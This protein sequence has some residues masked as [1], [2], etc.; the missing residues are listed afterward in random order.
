MRPQKRNLRLWALLL[1]VL[2]LV[3][4]ACGG[5]DDDDAGGTSDTTAAPADDETPTGDPFAPQPLD[6]PYTIKMTTPVR[7]EVFA[8]PLLADFFDELAAEN[9]TLEVTDTPT[10]EALALLDAGRT[11]VHVTSPVAGFFNA[12]DQ[13]LNVRWA[14]ASN[15]FGPDSPTG[16]Y[17]KPDLF[18]PD[19]TVD[20][21]DLE[22]ARIAL[23]PSGWGDLAAGFFR[24]WLQDNGLD[25]DDIDIQSFNSV[26]ALTQLE[27]GN[28][29]GAVLADPL[30]E[31]A[32]DRGF[33][34]LFLSF[35]EG[36]TFNGYFVGPNLLEENREAGE[37]F[38]RA[39]ARTTE[40]HLQGDYHDDTEVAEALAEVTG[41]PMENILATD[42]LLFD[43]TLALDPTWVME[44]Q[45]AWIA[46]G[47][48]LGYDEALPV[49]NWVDTSLIDPLAE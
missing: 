25:T 30:Y 27:A 11:D 33:G 4:T 24:T 15:Q 6:E 49:E 42:E 14:A 9:L 26:D 44:V 10:S 40:T 3:A 5:D 8:Q 31:Q 2:A 48:V 32:L 41:A 35:P 46:I 29:D 20:P 43:P 47:D 38:F 16:L 45:E 7:I 12:V 22:G 17:L 28:L 36:S 21:D 34:E 23:G 19:G 18:Q 1:A 39:I 37:A 13:G